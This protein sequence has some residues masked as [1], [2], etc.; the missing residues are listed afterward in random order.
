M[1]TWKPIKNFEGLYE[2]SDKGQVRSL[3]RIE[4]TSNGRK[5]FK[6]GQVRKLHD[7][8]RGYLC[9]DLWKN[10][11]SYWE[12]VHRLV[13]QA[14][15][16]NPDSLPCVNHK[17]YNRHNNNVDNLEWLSYKDNNL[18]SLPNYTKPRG[19]KV[20]KIVKCDM[21]GDELEVYRSTREAERA[22]HLANGVISQY[23]KKGYSQCGG[24][25]WK[26]IN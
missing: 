23:F 19:P 4:T 6:H 20:P 25:T 2:V 9:V 11:K 1:E 7:N 22:N 26:K 5:R 24:Y 15:I 16:P 14:F 18:Y 10:N 21:D 3:D 17:D 12:Y 13:A 8:G